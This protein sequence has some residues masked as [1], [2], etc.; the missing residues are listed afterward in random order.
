MES[1]LTIYDLPSLS[2]EETRERI[3]ATLARFPLLRELYGGSYIDELVR[4]RSD[5]RNSLLF[6]LV[7]PGEEASDAFWQ[8]IVEDLSL[9]DEENATN[10]FR[11]K[12][13][14]RTLHE[15]EGAKSE[16][17]LAAWAKRAGF[18]VTLEPVTNAPKKCE[19]SLETAPKTWWELKTP[20]DVKGPREDDRV[21][22]EVMRFFKRIP[23]P[24]VLSAKWQRIKIDEVNA[25]IKRI[26]RAIAEFHK[27][28]GGELP[29]R[30][31]DAGLVVTLEAR[32]KGDH[33]Y[34][35]SSSYGYVFQDENAAHV[36]K[37]VAKAVPQL[38]KE[39]A[40]IVVVDTTVA[41]WVHEEDVIDA[42][43]GVESRAAGPNGL[44]TV[45]DDNG[46]FQPQS[47][48]RLAAVAHYT[49]DKS[50]AWSAFRMMI[51]HNPYAHCR[52]PSELF[53]LPGIDQMRRE[54]AEGKYSLNRYQGSEDCVR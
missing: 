3:E 12:L 47:N 5:T 16:L 40:G 33:G 28:G 1:S 6:R 29:T 48:T 41:D 43:F 21:G 9:L 50:P 27:A 10:L 30:F 11:P 20:D 38:L 52:L 22:H 53:A 14:G 39:Q 35:G 24:Y 36:K 7:V 37:A 46:V 13:R 4:G 25:A 32:A 2:A 8:V 31:E 51:I 17:S 44:F 23:E 42:C 54:G 49:R 45:R 26:K 15:L 34:F 19:M 18:A